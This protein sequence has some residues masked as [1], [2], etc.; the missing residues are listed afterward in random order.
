MIFFLSF[1]FFIYLY[2]VIFFVLFCFCFCFLGHG[3]KLAPVVG[4][5]LGDLVMKRE[6]SYDLTPFRLDRFNPK[7]VL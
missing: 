1:I 5:I 6:N 3:F 2:V 7:S 4:K